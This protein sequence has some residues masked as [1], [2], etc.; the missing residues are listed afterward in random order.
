MKILIT[1]SKLK[2]FIKDNI[3]IDLTDK[4]QEITSVYSLLNDF[5]E[6]C[7]Y[8]YLRTRLNMHGPMYLITLEKRFKI[9]YQL[10]LDSKIPFIISNRCDYYT[11]QDFMEL[12]GEGLY[13]LGI[14]FEQLKNI[15]LTDER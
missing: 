7:S 10:N 1:E 4:I 3:G 14:R 11:E 8:H 9:L 15:Y 6:C 13:E 5:D 2:T 12:L